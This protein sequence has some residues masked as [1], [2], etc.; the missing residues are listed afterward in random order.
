MKLLLVPLLLTV[1][2]GA[3]PLTDDQ[4]KKAE[5]FALGCL[6]QHKGLTQEHLVLL[7]DG[8]FSKVDGE[9]KCFLRCFL[10]QANFMDASGKLQNDYAIERLSVSR[11]KPKVEALV[12]K[13]S[14]G[15]EV[16]DSC[17]TAFRAVE[18]YHREK[19]SLL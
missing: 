7:R 10:Q 17:E 15:V 9:T 5:G 16:E 11:E 3:Q 12:K 4:M 2:V 19:A 13:C 8:D 6:A 18:C 1:C 14:T